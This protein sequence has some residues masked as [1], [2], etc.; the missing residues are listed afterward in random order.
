MSGL[1]TAGQIRRT[2]EEAK[3][4]SDSEGGREGVWDG[5]DWEGEGRGG[6]CTVIYILCV[7]V[8]VKFYDYEYYYQGIHYTSLTLVLR[9]ILS[10]G[11]FL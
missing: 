5:Q 9:Y 1:P 3:R 7:C 6:G 8:C 11:N 4:V 2:G 10:T